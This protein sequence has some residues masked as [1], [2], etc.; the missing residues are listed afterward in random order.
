VIRQVFRTVPFYRERW[1]LVSRDP[2]LADEVQRRRHDLVPLAGGAFAVNPYRGLGP[3]VS[4]TGRLSAGAL[5]AVV[6]DLPPIGPVPGLAARTR[7]RCLPPAGFPANP[8]DRRFIRT[9]ELISRLASGER[10]AVLGPEIELDRLVDVASAAATP[11]LLP[12]Y[13]AREQVPAH[14]QPGA[15]LRDWLLG[16]LGAFCDCGRWHLDWRRVYAAD[17]EHGVAFTIL[18][19]AS[20]RLVDVL[21]APGLRMRVERCA[22]HGTP[23]LAPVAGNT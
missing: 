21:L 6:T 13:S 17:T 2:V 10:V 7:L 11:S 1:A 23:V 19:Q 14:T 18:P 12:L 4:L 20:P 15:V 16:Y 9:A 22:E 8:F 5:L 3:V